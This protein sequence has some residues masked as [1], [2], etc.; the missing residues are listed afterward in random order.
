MGVGGG[1]GSNARSSKGGGGDAAARKKAKASGDDCLRC[2][3]CDQTP[4][5][6][7]WAK[8]GPDGKTPT[9]M[10]CLSHWTVYLRGWQLVVE[11]AD[12]ADMYEN[13]KT[14]KAEVDK[15]TQIV[16]GA[17]QP[18]FPH[19]VSQDDEFAVTIKRSKVGISRGD[20]VNMFGKKPSEFGVTENDLVDERKRVYKGVL[21]DHPFQ[22]WVEYEVAQTVRLTAKQLIMQQ[23]KQVRE[24]QPQAT[25]DFKRDKNE[26]SS[27]WMGKVRSCSVTIDDVI[28]AT[29]IV[30]QFLRH[31]WNAADDTGGASGSGLTR[32]EQRSG[33]SADAELEPINADVASDSGDEDKDDQEMRPKSQDGP[34]L[35][36]DETT[37]VKAAGRKSSGDAGSSCRKAAQAA[38][39]AVSTYSGRSGQ[40]PKSRMTVVEGCRDKSLAV[41]TL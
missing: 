19:E 25:I 7:K 35:R 1:T 2:A 8:Y 6:V 33:E 27:K 22:P 4:A 11:F 12:W 16:E 37:P 24:N 14:C 39:D 29:G 9:G 41:L 28:K 18:W 36:T 13:D 38:D 21:I 17:A 23:E 40:M 30:P 34:I 20:F 3:I 32:P 15:A 26:R 31:G 5:Q 10:A